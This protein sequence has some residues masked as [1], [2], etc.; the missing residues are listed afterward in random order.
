M[1][2]PGIRAGRSVPP[3][4]PLLGKVKLAFLALSLLAVVSAHFRAF[5]LT[6]QAF[7]HGF[8]N[9]IGQEH[10]WDMFSSDPRGTSVDLWAEVVFANRGKQQWRIDRSRVGG[11]FAYYH[12]VQWMETAVLEPNKAQLDGLADWLAA[13]SPVPVDEV[14]I[15]GEQRIGVPPGEPTPGAEVAELGRFTPLR[16]R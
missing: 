3:T 5:P 2:D 6:V 14:V 11:D 1:V 7:G 15:F 10:R 8:A 9:L 4:L 12:W 13:I 16:W